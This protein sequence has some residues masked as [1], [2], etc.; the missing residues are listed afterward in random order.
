LL[1][2][3]E[4]RRIELILHEQ[5]A[6]SG[7]ALAGSA[8]SSKGNRAQRQFEIG[9]TANYGGIVAAEFE[10]CARK[11]LGQSRRDARVARMLTEAGHEVF[12]PTLTGVGERFAAMIHK[13]KSDDVEFL[14]KGELLELATCEA[15][16]VMNR[17]ETG[18]LA[19]GN[20]ADVVII[21]LDKPNCLPVY[22]EAAA[23]S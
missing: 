13:D 19:P 10:Y 21:D 2:P 23:P 14:K 7:A 12:T 11:T 9:G 22:D 18:V 15:A 3:L 4:E 16:K 20:K 1:Q 8:D 6:Q 5:A 17:P